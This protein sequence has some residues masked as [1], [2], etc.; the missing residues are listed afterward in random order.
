M[1]TTN[2]RYKTIKRSASI[3]Y[4][5][6]FLRGVINYSYV[7]SRQYNVLNYDMELIAFKLIDE[8][9]AIC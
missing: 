1:S 6:F 2:K 7:S 4:D 8:H 5:F 9:S 3:G